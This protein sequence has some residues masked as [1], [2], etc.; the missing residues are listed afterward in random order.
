MSIHNPNNTTWIDYLW[1]IVPIGQRVAANA[2]STNL[3]NYFPSDND[4]TTWDNATELRPD[5]PGTGPATHLLSAGLVQQNVIDDLPIDIPASNT[6]RE[7]EGWTYETVLADAG[8]EVI[9]Q[10]VI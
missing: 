4:D 9:E 7:S 8:M 6:W 1:T 10:E 3:G 5:N 2:R